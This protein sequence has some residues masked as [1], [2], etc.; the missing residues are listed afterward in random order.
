MEF[1]NENEIPGDVIPR[2]ERPRTPSGPRGIPGFPRRQSEGILNR[3]VNFF[4]EI[5]GMGSPTVGPDGEVGPDGDPNER[6]VIAFI[7]RTFSGLISQ[8]M[9]IFN[10]NGVG[11]Q[12]PLNPDA[13]EFP[14]QRPRLEPLRRN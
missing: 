4:K 8:V 7:R 5:L 2:E 9:K 10:G 12:N 6:G 13:A 1:P 11:G 14:Y 3:I